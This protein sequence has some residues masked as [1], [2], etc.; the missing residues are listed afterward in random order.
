M[1]REMSA[2]IRL[3]KGD[4]EQSMGT[5]NSRD[6]EPSLGAI[7]KGSLGFLGKYF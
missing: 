4:I 6:C 5:I 7:S 2:L 1:Q 3:S